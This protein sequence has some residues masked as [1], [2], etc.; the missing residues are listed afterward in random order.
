ME[1]SLKKYYLL[2]YVYAFSFL[3]YSVS[4][5]FKL[6]MN[7]ILR[8]PFTNIRYIDLIIA[9]IILNFLINLFVR[10]KKIKFNYLQILI[11]VFLVN[12]II[13]FI[14]TL[15]M[16]NQDFNSIFAIFISSLSIFF[17][18]DISSLKLSYKDIKPITVFAGIASIFLLFDNLVRLF[19]S[20][21]GISYAAFKGRLELDV[22]EYVLTISGVCLYS[23]VTIYSFIYSKFEIKKKYK[24]FLI[25]GVIAFIIQTVISFGRGY[26]AIWGILLFYFLIEGNLSNKIKNIILGIA[27]TLGLSLLLSNTLTSLGYNP[28]EKLT[29]LVN[30]TLNY[31]D[32]AWEKGRDIARAGAIAYWEENP[33]F[34]QGYI[35]F[36]NNYLALPHNFFVTSLV[37]RG[38]FGTL[39]LTL[40]LIICYRNSIR[41]W[42]LTKNINPEQKTVIHCLIITAWIWIVPLMTQEIFIER[43]STSAQFVY[44]GMIQGLYNYYINIKNE[45]E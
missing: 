8:I 4:A 36:Y 22:G 24:F 39:I 20:N 33:I 30:Y 2:L 44:L 26:L 28:I 42:K 14:Q 7:T 32:P 29:D 34:G 3:M 35:D 27:I 9:I 21:K 31:E 23:V 16:H 12:E 45:K 38:I 40:I 11:F 41:L 10:Q 19:G 15:G 17:I 37:T 5:L 13:I 18:I 6:N 25:L 1:K 43:Y